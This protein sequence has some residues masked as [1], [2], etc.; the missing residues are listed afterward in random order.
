MSIFRIPALGYG[1]NDFTCE[2][3]IHPH[4]R[5]KTRVFPNPVRLEADFTAPS[6]HPHTTDQVIPNLVWTITEPAVAIICACLPLLRP[7]FQRPKKPL[8]LLRNKWNAVQDGHRGVQPQMAMEPASATAT[9]PVQ[10]LGDTSRS[11]PVRSSPTRSSPAGSS[12]AASLGQWSA[13]HS[14][15]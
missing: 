10:L 2:S 9:P 5:I 7:L 14:L 6:V 12:P 1:W 3:S 11:T 4:K 8:P 13:E 15:F